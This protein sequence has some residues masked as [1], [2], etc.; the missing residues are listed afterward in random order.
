MDKITTIDSIIR[1]MKVYDSGFNQ[2]FISMHIIDTTDKDYTSLII[3]MSIQETEQLIN[4]L[5]KH[6]QSIKED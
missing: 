1:V 5:S 4:T 2:N 3:H 6:I